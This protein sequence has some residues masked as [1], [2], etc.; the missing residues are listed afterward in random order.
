MS[1][2]STADTLFK[3]LVLTLVHSLVVGL[4][5]ALLAV[6]LV[7]LAS[8][9]V[10]A[11]AD[12]VSRPLE[13]ISVDEVK[14]G[15]LL[16]RLAD[17]SS[18]VDAPQLSTHVAMTI[19]GMSARVS[20]K[21]R[22]RNPGSDWVEG[23]YVFPLPE[24]AAVDRMRLRIGERLIEGEIEE[25]VAAEKRYQQAKLAG[26][27][28]SL[29]SQERA[30]IFTTA[31]ANI[32]PGEEVIVEIEYQQ[33]LTY[34]QGSFSIRFPLVVAPRYIPG[35]PVGE[36]LVAHIGDQGWMGN[37][38]QVPDAARITPPVAATG[39]GVINPV[40]IEIRLAAGLPL[41]RLES[42]YH[43][44]ESRRDERDVHHI[45]LDGGVVPADRDFELTWTPKS[46][47][48]PVA[49]LFSEEWQQRQY[50]L[51]MVMPPVR[52]D[53][54]TPKL[55]REVVF[56]IDTSGSMHGDS[57][58]QAREALKLALRRLTPADRFNVIR[59][60]HQT[61]GLFGQALAATEDNLDLALG[62]VGGLEADGGT[63]MMPA[64]ER[65]LDGRATEG[66]LRQVVFLT[67]G[68]VGNEEALFTVIQ[69]RL[70]DS[71]LFT[72]GIGSAPNSFFM[73]RA[74]A[75]GRGTFTY[76]GK[77]EE[78]KEKMNGLFA[79]LESPVLTDITISWSGSAVEMW[80]QTIPDLYRGE[81]VVVAVR[82]DQAV[83][84]A[85]ISGK[86]GGK[87]WRQQVQLSGGGSGAGIHLLWARS[88]IADLMAQA[89]RGRDESEI[90]SEVLPLALE[91]RLVSRYT[92][93]VAVDKTPVRPQGAGWS[94]KPVASRLPHGWSA[95]K[96]FGQ[97]PQTATPARFQQ[98]IGLFLLLVAGWVWWCSITTGRGRV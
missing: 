65:A 64:L 5:V 30:N 54:L 17:G 29:L 69:Q 39:E 41:A 1:H 32:A 45:R 14:R 90:R 81:P 53:P 67:D 66:F 44:I 49:A 68:S 19:E 21:Q 4:V 3:D 61:H 62:Y 40:T 72:V 24:N 86:V 27:K 13:P 85:E 7:L 82:L 88:K 43:A 58:T 36:T 37:T 11:A 6:V 70:G 94:E 16:L 71:R 83:E 56:V 95:G 2:T 8:T 92:S 10:E 47:S 77:V 80:P 50:A 97:L 12:V 31:V 48:A 38:D 59:F 33:T 93:L 15:S 74:A 73:T 18:Q 55:P 35:V 20:V 26:K 46:G 28:A 42:T 34:D 89:S 9:P 23:R 63:E 22:F 76:I 96:V 78:V 91:H 52:H 25:R 87:A 84:R 51:M 57:I 79:K 60:N 75:F 98:L